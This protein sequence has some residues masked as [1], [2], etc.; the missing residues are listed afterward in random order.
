MHIDFSDMKFQWSDLCNIIWT[1]RAQE[2]HWKCDIYFQMFLFIQPVG[3]W[4]DYALKFCFLLG[5]LYISV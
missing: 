4:W 3:F 5:L 2:P 1:V